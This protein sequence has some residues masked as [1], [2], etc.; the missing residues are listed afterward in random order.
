MNANNH[1]NYIGHNHQFSSWK[2]LNNTETHYILHKYHVKT[3]LWNWKVSTLFC[4][5]A[6]RVQPRLLPG[7][8]WGLISPAG[9]Q[10]GFC[11]AASVASRSKIRK[12]SSYKKGQ[13]RICWMCQNWHRSQNRTATAAEASLITGCQIWLSPCSQA[14]KLRHSKLSRAL[15]IFWVLNISLEC[16]RG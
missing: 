1:G 16:R 8:S 2:H 6:G 15:N 10:G 5:W 7:N 4:G 12:T 3:F 11:C 14:T 13:K 9:D